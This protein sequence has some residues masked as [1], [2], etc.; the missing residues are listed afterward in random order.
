MAMKQ[1]MIGSRSR[2]GAFALA[3]MALLAVLATTLIGPADGSEQRSPRSKA[4]AKLFGIASQGPFNQ[5]IDLPAMRE[6]NVANVRTLMVP[7]LMQGDSGT[8][9]A[10]GGA[11]DWTE[12]DNWIGAAAASGAIAIPF[13]VT[14]QASNPFTPPLSGGLLTKWREYLTAAVQRYGP[15]GAYWNGPFQSQFPGGNPKPVNV[16]QIWNEPGSPTYFAPKPSVSKYAKLLKL[17]ADIIH[18]VDNKAKIMLAGLFAS[19]DKG[20]VRGRIVAVKFLEK[21]YKINGAKQAFDIAAVHPYSRSVS[22]VIKVIE[23]IREVMA[24]NGDGRKKLAVSELGW[25]SNKPNGSILAK[26]TKG[27]TNALKGAFKKLLAGRSKFK[28]HSVSWFCLRD[29]DP[30]GPEQSCPNCPYAGLL[31]LGG[32][33][34]PSFNAFKSFTR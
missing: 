31:K 20:A 9:T 34:K 33:P 25:S 21:L 10:Q 5:A 29:I 13:I 23:E 17:S 14:S 15:G 18:Q 26:G 6:A 16:W 32:G 4:G 30:A 7:Y 27:Q 22:G 3:F 1:T 24:K 19:P 2:I 11:C 8:C 12:P 28:L